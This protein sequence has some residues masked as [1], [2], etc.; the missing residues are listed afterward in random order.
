MLFSPSNRCQPT[1][2]ILDENDSSISTHNICLHE[3]RARFNFLPNE[4]LR[5]HSYLRFIFIVYEMNS[6]FAMH[7]NVNFSH[8]T[9]AH[10]PSRMIFLYEMVALY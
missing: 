6:I 7:S 1:Q 3:S 8:D 4:L 5:M 10:F 2:N 9:G